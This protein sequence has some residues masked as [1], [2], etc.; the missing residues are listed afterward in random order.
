MRAPESDR[1][2]Q[3]MLASY[4]GL[5]SEVDDNLGRLFE[6]LKSSGQWDSTL[7]IFTSDHGDP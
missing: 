7:I 2:L 3:R 6:L 5:I 4:Y 1:V